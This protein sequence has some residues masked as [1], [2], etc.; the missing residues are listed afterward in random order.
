MPR[1]VVIVGG[2]A[3]GLATAIF[4]A[5]TAPDLRITVVDGARTLGA[6]I[7]VSGGGRCNV[8]NA[9]VT[10]RDF[11]GATPGAIRTVLRAFGARETA[12]W[13]RTI[14]V[15]LHEENLGKLFPD[16]NRARDVLDALVNEARAAGVSIVTSARVESIERDSTGFA[17][18]TSQRRVRADAV[19]IATG[20]L[21]L[22]KSGSDGAGY[23][24]AAAFG[25][26]LVATTPALVPLILEGDRHVGLSGVTHD[27]SLRLWRVDKPRTVVGSYL[28]THTGCSGP[29]ALDIS[30][31]LLR[32]R[33][34]GKL[35]LLSLDS[36]GES[37]EA[38]EAW[39]TLEQQFRP[40]A[41]PVTV[42]ADRIPRA[43]A[44]RLVFEAGIDPTM[45]LAMLTREARRRLLHAMTSLSLDVR[46]ARSYTHAEAT[47]GGVTMAEV[48]PATMQSRVCPG[49][50]L[51]G[52]VLDVDGRLG[53]FNFQWAWSSARQCARGL[54][55]RLA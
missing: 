34:D 9:S 45:T 48:D 16:T 52:E 33:L 40:R 50:F 20:G 11:N 29:A 55:L 53:G 26:T 5:R 13:F 23:R 15:P 12:D 2:G 37:F 51:V 7:L 14:G 42:A 32:A 36:V 25:H 39:W 27:V 10:E 49:L 3:A 1:D 21:A 41:N 43:L 44:E 22:P 6:K 35:P 46:D 47:A 30:R 28:W 8:T 38:V 4:A 18:V 17:I 24:F 19:V 54:A 31:H